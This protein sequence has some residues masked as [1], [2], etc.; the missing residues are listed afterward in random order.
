[1]SNLNRVQLIG[2]LGQDP[3]SCFTPSGKRVTRFSVATHRKWT[4]QD[5]EVNTATDW[6]NVE[7]WNG[8]AEAVDTYLSK[9]RKVYVEGRLQIDRYEKDGQSCQY[10]K[11]VATNVIF[12]DGPVTAEEVRETETESLP[13]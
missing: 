12:L 13:F 9:G 10:V 5:G 8:L 6:F 7:C 2:N 11:V 3:D 4:S 1:M